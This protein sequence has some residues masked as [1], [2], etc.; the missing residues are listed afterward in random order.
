MMGQYDLRA[1]I[2]A[3]R[4]GVLV[5]ELKQ[6]ANEQPSDPTPVFLLAYISY[7]TGFTANA[8]GYL[9]LADQRAGAGR[10]PFYGNLKAHWS[11]GSTQSPDK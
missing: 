3:D 9:D 5:N 4:L 6:L 7:N 2:G 10:D 1:M 8:E 11:L